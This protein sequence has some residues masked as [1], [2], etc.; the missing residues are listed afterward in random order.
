MLCTTVANWGPHIRWTGYP[1]LLRT[2]VAQPAN[3]YWYPGIQ[4][5]SANC[6]SIRYEKEHEIQKN[7]IISLSL[8]CSFVLCRFYDNCNLTWNRAPFLLQIMSLMSHQWGNKVV[9]NLESWSSTSSLLQAGSL[10]CAR[11]G[12]LVVVAPVC[13][14]SVRFPTHQLRRVSTLHQTVVSEDELLIQESFRWWQCG[15]RH[16]PPPHTHTPPPPWNVGAR[17]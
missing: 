1:V 10:W 5:F 2:T 12:N 16:S 4:K 14:V 13:K 9:L 15:V 17:Q 11:G 3:W 8:V 7:L 6:W